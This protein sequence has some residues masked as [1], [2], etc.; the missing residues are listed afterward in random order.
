MKKLL[1]FS[2]GNVILLMF[3]FHFIGDVYR[4]TPIYIND[5]IVK[6]QNYRY[7]NSDEYKLSQME[8]EIELLKQSIELS[9]SRYQL[10]KELTDLYSKKEL[11]EQKQEYLDRQKTLDSLV[12]ERDKFIGK[13]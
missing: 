12:E 8:S 9:K 4:Q 10:S 6:Y 2:W 3:L 5:A 11:D 13:K 1:V 7:T